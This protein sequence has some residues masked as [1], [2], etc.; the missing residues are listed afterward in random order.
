[1]IEDKR[2]SL[3]NL[4]GGPGN[5]SSAA[6]ELADF[7]LQRVLD[8]I[9]DENTK[10]D[11]VREVTLKIRIKPDKLR[12]SCDVEISSTSKLAPISPYP[13]R[14]YVGRENGRG[15]AIEDDPKQRNMFK[16]LANERLAVAMEAGNVLPIGQKGKSE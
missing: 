7:E 11:A 5:T 9:V 10:P 3:A 4:G 12:E 16:E 13:T 8:N 2:V 6:I 14:F 15:V 1:M